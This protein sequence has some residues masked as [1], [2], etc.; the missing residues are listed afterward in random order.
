MSGFEWQTSPS[1]ALVLLYDSYAAWLY[2]AVVTLCEARAPEIEAW[3]KHN[4][5][6]TDRTGLARKTL[7]ARVIAGIGEVVVL[8]S[9][10]MTYGFWLET[11]H[12]GKY[13]ILSPAIDYW[14]P[15]IIRDLQALMS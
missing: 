14:L 7:T 8:L 1:E 11:R 13:A 4:A 10:G 2:Q 12:A 3:M 9:H 5:T 15:V 6:W